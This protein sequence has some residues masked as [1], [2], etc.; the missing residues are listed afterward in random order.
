VLE[1]AAVPR[2]G[3]FLPVSVGGHPRIPGG[4]IRTADWLRLEKAIRKPIDPEVR[5][6]IEVINYDYLTYA[7]WQSTAIP[8]SPV[9]EDVL[10]IKSAAAVF[11]NAL[12]LKDGFQARHEIETQLGL[13]RG[14]LRDAALG[15]LREL[16]RGCDA[17]VG[18]LKT[19]EGY[20]PGEAWDIWIKRL[21]DILK[22]AGLRVGVSKDGTSPFVVFV[23]E[24]QLCFPKEFRRHT[25]SAATKTDTALAD[26]IVKARRA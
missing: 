9:I 16:T 1:A 15:P 12:L 23:A 7:I 25:R 6:K 22:K 14:A 13:G 5:S 19:Q 26:A 3:K 17:V 24:L 2:V 8:A 20:A 11:G 10:A 18:R 21:T 4:R